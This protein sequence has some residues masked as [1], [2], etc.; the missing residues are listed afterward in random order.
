MTTA[1]LE[2]R[3]ALAEQRI[4]TLEAQNANL[5]TKDEV[6]AAILNA[7]NTLTWRLITS[8]I[9]LAGVIV[10]AMAAAAFVVV[11]AISIAA[12]S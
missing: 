5:A 2:E 3:L 8:L 4:S 10:A 7:V 6:D 1:T 9:A 12:G 11:N